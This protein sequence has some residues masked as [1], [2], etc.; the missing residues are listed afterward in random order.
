MRCPRRS[1]PRR[2]SFG[3]PYPDS[4][5]YEELTPSPGPPPPHNPRYMAVW[6][7]AAVGDGR[8]AWN[9]FLPNEEIR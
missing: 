5:V 1:A 4:V 9:F 8:P 7:R 3:G 2:F 6:C